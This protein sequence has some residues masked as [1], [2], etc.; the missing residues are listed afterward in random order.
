MVGDVL[1]HKTS[2]CPAVGET[3]QLNSVIH[4]IQAKFKVVDEKRGKGGWNQ[5]T[6]HLSNYNGKGKALASKIQN[7]LTD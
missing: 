5:C 3:P 2:D 7:L 1:E 6:N 4:G